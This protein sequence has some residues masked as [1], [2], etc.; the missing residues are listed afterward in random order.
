[1]M[2]ALTILVKL[3]IGLQMLMNV[4]LLFIKQMAA[5]VWLAIPVLTYA[6]GVTLP[7]LTQMILSIKTTYPHCMT[8]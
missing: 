6:K 8:H 5:P 4:S 1:M 7:L 3:Q 2:A